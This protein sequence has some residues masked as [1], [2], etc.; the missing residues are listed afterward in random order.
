MY[1]SI[2]VGLFGLFQCASSAP[3][4]SQAPTATVEAGA[5][6]GTAISTNGTSAT[7]VN[8]YL[9]VPFAASPTRFAPPATP[10]PWSKP[11]DATNFSFTC[12]QQFNYPEAA[13][14]QSMEFYNL[15]LQADEGEDCLNLNIWTPATPGRNKTVMV[16]IYGGGLN[17]G[18]NSLT[19]YDGTSFAANQD[20]VVVSIN[21]RTNLYG[22]PGAPQLPFDELNL[23]FLDQ[24]FALAWIQRNIHAFGGDPAKVTIF[25]ESA[26]GASVDLLVLTH[27]KRPPFRA[28]I[29][30]SGTA[31]LYSGLQ[32]KNNP[33]P[34]N[35]MVQA[36]NCS[37]ASDILACV[38]AV[39]QPVLTSTIEHLANEFR[40]V[41]DNITVP[42]HPETLRR[43]GKIAHVPI[44][45]GSNANEGRIF[46]LPSVN[47]TSAIPYITALF[48]ISDQQAQAL[49]SLYPIPS[50]YISNAYEQISQI[51]TDFIFTCPA[52]LQ[53]NG[54]HAAKIM[55]PWRYFYNASFANLNF[56]SVDL[57]VYHSSEIVSVFG[58]YPKVG[59][60][61]HQVRLSQ[62]MQ[63]AWA[64]FAKNPA[65]GPGWKGWPNVE[66][67]G[68]NA[69][70][71]EAIGYSAPA[72]RVDSKCFA[73]QP[74]YKAVG[75]F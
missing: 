30:E 39:P 50:E 61:R 19:V 12:P 10:T 20:V 63:S 34:W 46:N 28:A 60:T 22:F 6:I 4:A 2:F 32:P 13:R 5:V 53:F 37:N 26:G 75:V 29:T 67:L 31:V 14:N 47:A 16:W 7:V 17:F 36:V 74:I 41:I 59:T 64:T 42:A 25:G 23:G 66:V 72:R 49:A 51:Q 48:S 27:P 69:T 52:G 68:S 9:G 56:G 54:T 1:L 11:Y 15:G 38:R 70:G 33:Q 8:R 44:L 65:K 45:T 3:T 73:Y 58:T 57:G 18:S 71:Q 24:R 35:A 21:Y 43:S 40:P 62:Y 55:S